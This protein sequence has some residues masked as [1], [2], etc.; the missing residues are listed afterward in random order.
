MTVSD[1]TVKTIHGR[2]A[3]YT[4]LVETASTEKATELADTLRTEVDPGGIRQEL[5]VW[6]LPDDPAV[7]DAYTFSK[8][9]A[10]SAHTY[11]MGRAAA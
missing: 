8:Q 10:E 2:A 1:I 5:F 11:L 7:V 3:M 6:R 4:I 9:T